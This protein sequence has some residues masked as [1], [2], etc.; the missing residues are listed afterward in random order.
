[1]KEG[2]I[3]LMSSIPLQWGEVSMDDI[4]QGKT[5]PAALY[6][7][8]LKNHYVTMI[9]TV[10]AIKKLKPDLL[11]MVQPR[12]LEP[13]GL[14]VLDQWVR[15]GGRAI[16]FA[17]P[18]LQWPSDYPLGDSRRPLFTSFLSPLFAHWG[19]ELVLPVTNDEE[20]VTDVQV[21]SQTLNLISH[22][23]WLKKGSQASSCRIDAS[24]LIATCSLGKGRAILIADADLLEDTQLSNGLLQSSQSIWVSRLINDQLGLAKSPEGVQ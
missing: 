10:G 24:A 9:D 2:K 8:L 19:L 16:I 23:N 4:A 11:I 12:L 21:G 20:Q 3:A 6:S 7:Q 14:L 22:G 13:E 18:A 5:K 15:K 1:M 17:D